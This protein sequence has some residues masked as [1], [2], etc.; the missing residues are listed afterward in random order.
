[1]ENKKPGYKTTEFWFGIGAIIVAALIAVDVFAAGSTAYKLLTAAG[2]ALNALGYGMSRR[3]VKAAGTAVLLILVM[4]Q[5]ACARAMYVRAVNIEKGEKH[6]ADMGKEST[7]MT[8]AYGPKEVDGVMKYG[9]SWEC[10]CSE[11][12]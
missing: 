10:E 11:V 5:G 6:C 7:C 2:L 1:M 8:S 12:K 4:S 9:W 3:T